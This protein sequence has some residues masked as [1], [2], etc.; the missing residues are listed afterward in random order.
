MSDKEKSRSGEIISDGGGG[1]VAPPSSLLKRVAD[2]VE[3]LV[4]DLVPQGKPGERELSRP[5]HCRRILRGH[6]KG[7][8]SLAVSQDGSILASGGSYETARLWRLPDGEFIRQ[9]PHGQGVSCLGMT[10]D[11][12]LLISGDNDGTVR[13]WSLPEGELRKT[14]E[15]HTWVVQCVAIGSDGKLFATGSADGSL[16]LGSIHGRAGLHSRRTPRLC[17]MSR[18]EPRWSISG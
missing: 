9:L 16:A 11:N 2:D 14:L 15:A 8:T 18:D 1:I 12:R 6:T 17:R 10:Q 3:R 7:V 13:L 4:G 5:W